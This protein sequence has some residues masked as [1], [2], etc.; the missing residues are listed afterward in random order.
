MSLVHWCGSSDSE[1]SSDT[2][3]LPAQASPP[4]LGTYTARN[5]KRYGSAATCWSEM[6]AITIR[7]L[8]FCASHKPMSPS[9]L[10]CST[11]SIDSAS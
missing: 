3:H 9:M 1:T 8:A 4:P 11:A 7:P 5:L 10:T 6:P 2:C